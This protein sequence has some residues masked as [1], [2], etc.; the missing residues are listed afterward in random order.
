M[1][2]IIQ[3]KV[4]LIDSEPLI[5]REIHVSKETTFFELHHIIQIIMGWKNYHMFEFN[6]EGY[7]VGEVFEDE[8]TEG[9]GNDQIIESRTVAIKDLITQQKETFKYVYD[10]GDDWEHKIQVENFLEEDTTL[11]FP[12]CIDGR[13]NCPPDD[14]GGLHNFYESM[15]ILK[16]KKHPEYKEI[17]KW[18]GKSYDMKKFDKEKINRQL[19][20]L[21]KYIA[22][23]DS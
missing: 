4:S 12:I 7:R 10:Y 13:M 19:K 20:N 5:W 18:F 23:W 9:Y 6:L 22:D 14:S 15:E 1:T 3:L 8:R 11:K 21:A 16:D 2:D 17:S